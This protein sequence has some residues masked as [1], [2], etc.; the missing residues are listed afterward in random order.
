MDDKLTE[1][2]NKDQLTREDV[3]KLLKK[4]GKK[5]HNRQEKRDAILALGKENFQGISLLEDL[6]SYED[7]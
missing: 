4:I 6:P 7:Y 5:G 1:L 2:R 3:V